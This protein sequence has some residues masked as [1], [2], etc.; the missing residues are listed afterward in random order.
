MQ[1]AQRHDLISRLER[2][3]W[4]AAYFAA[5][6]ALSIELADVVTHLTPSHD[7]ATLAG[8][9]TMLL[10]IN[11][12]RTT[13][14]RILRALSWG[15]RIVA[16]RLRVR[17]NA[18]AWLEMTHN[19]V[20]K[21]IDGIACYIDGQAAEQRAAR[22]QRLTQVLDLLREV[23]PERYRRLKRLN[24]KIFVGRVRN[25]RAAGGQLLGTS[26]I[27]LV[28]SAMDRYRIETLVCVLCHELSHLYIAS[29]GAP[30]TPNVESRME[31]IAGRE[32]ELWGRRLIGA[33]VAID[34]DGWTE[35]AQLLNGQFYRWHWRRDG[36][37]VHL[38]S[39]VSPS[40]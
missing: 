38:S 34:R 1:I 7:A 39:L 3:L 19:V 25:K 9:V 29:L 2:W 26:V 35:L 22:E 14:G 20:P 32:M 28:D 10:G 40:R 30:W 36:T 33:G 21:L 5:V 8:S 24:A 12:W 13:R 6:V 15:V 27:L 11:I 37:R 4:T 17:V 18:I 16:R 23:W 31:S